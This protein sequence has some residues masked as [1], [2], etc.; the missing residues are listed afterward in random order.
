MQIDIMDIKRQ[1]PAKP[2]LALIK[3]LV[4]FT[5]IITL[6]MVGYQ[7]NGF[8]IKKIDKQSLMIATVERDQL[9]VKVFGS[10]RLLPKQTY[11]LANHVPGRVKNLLVKPG[12]RVTTGQLLLELQ[13]IELKQQADKGFWAFTSAQAEFEAFKVENETQR[14]EQQAQI[15]SS[16][17]KLEGM[18]IQL[19][20]EKQL[21]EQ[22]NA[23]ISAL[24]HKK[25][26]LLVRKLTNQLQTDQQRLA[27]LKLN[28]TAKI[29]A[30]QANL[31]LIEKEW[32]QAKQQVEWLQVKAT[33]SGVIQ[34]VDVELGQR[35]ISGS[36]LLMLADQSQLIAEIEVPEYAINQ[37]ALTQ[38]VQLDTRHQLISGQVSRIEPAVVNGNVIVEVAITE[39]LPKEARPDLAITAQIAVSTVP[40]ALIIRRPAI[41][42]SNQFGVLYKLDNQSSV[43]RKTQVSFGLGSSSQIQIKDGLN[44]GDQVVISD[45]SAWQHLPSIVIN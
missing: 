15:V 29:Q 4:A 32:A 43:A 23:T 10:G 19:A 28:I 14:L 39:P 40:N 12:S 31:Q 18:E 38:A 7:Q 21:F 13:N 37:V 45:H 5:I 44:E 16:Q 25:T 36:N 2:Y 22:G 9:Q 20:A 34:Q 26:Q 42:Q 27:R 11:W 8:G 6:V 30:K 17:L 33:H 41:A 1:K 3:G 24:E 35:L